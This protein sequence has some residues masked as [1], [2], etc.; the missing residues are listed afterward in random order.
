MR[1]QRVVTFAITTALLFAACGDESSSSSN[2]SESIGGSTTPATDETATTTAPL[3]S[4]TAATDGVPATEAPTSGD[5]DARAQRRVQAALDSL[6]ADWLGT[7]ASDLGEEGASGD[8]IVFSA[9]LTATDYNLDNLDA[10]SA[11]SWELDAEGPETGTPFG[12]AN[13]SVEARV[14]KAETTADAAYAVLE[15]I[16]GTDEGRDCLA[17]EAPG[18]LAVDAPEGTTLEGRVEGTTISGVDVGAR[19]IVSFNGGGLAGEFYVDL[20]ASKVDPTCTIFATFISFL[21]PVDQ[22]VASAM[23]VA[24]ANAS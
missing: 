15:R 2:S 5:A 21:V 13:A 7:V 17:R 6:P 22:S 8:D 23:F 9:C 16:L 11:A 18:R 14:F 3:D 19:L 12:G 20:V 10:D 1:A 4:V 24:A